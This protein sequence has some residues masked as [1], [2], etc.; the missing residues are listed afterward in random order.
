MKKQIPFFLILVGILVLSN[1][2]ISQEVDALKAEGKSA[3]KYGSATAGI[4]CGD[5]LCSESETE[6]F[7]QRS[8]EMEDISDIR[9]EPPLKQIKMGMN[10]LEILCNEGLELV[11]K[12]GNMPACV[13]P[14]SISKLLERGWIQS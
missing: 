13:K 6:N 12:I 11:V 1:L 5:R 9:Y 8:T 3:W 2:S 14:Q 7:E 4:V 10:P